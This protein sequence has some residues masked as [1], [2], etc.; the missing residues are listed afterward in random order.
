MKTLT[1]L[2][3]ILFAAILLSACNKGANAEKVQTEAQM[4]ESLIKNAKQMAPVETNK[5]YRAQINYPVETS[6]GWGIICETNI[7]EDN[8]NVRVYPSLEAEIV[9]QLKKDTIVEIQGFSHEKTTIDGFEGNWVYV[10]YTVGNIYQE[11]NVE[12]WVFSKYV[13][14]GD[15]E[16]APIKFVE[17]SGTDVRISYKIR[18]EEIFK[19]VQVIKQGPYTFNKGVHVTKE[20]DYYV[21][22]WGP[23]EYQDYHYSTIPGV[24]ILTADTYELKHITYF[25][26]FE[27]LGHDWISFLN[28]FDYLVLDSGIGRGVRGI[29]AWRLRDMKRVF[30]GG[31]EGGYYKDE[32]TISVVYYYK[33]TDDE[34]IK[35]Y[36]KTYEKENPMPPDI[37]KKRVETG[38]FPELLIN[39]SV[40]LETGERKITGGEYILTE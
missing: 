13:N 7:L 12:G 19:D 2:I 10:F 24:Y 35:S 38:L 33:Y 8:V 39:C 20:G 14:T 1:K 6:G 25:G 17:M 36:G 5:T 22:I 15:I 16:A 9:Y 40:D 11:G 18:G 34:E 29:T 21:F 27:D 37:E 30:D 28:G 3:L 23:Y 31:W 4:I 26:A 32:H